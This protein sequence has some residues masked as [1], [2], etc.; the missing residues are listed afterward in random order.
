MARLEEGTALPGAGRL[1]ERTR[2]I[3]RSTGAE[4]DGVG[5]RRGE[6]LGPE[7]VGG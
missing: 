2:L 5:G 7:V 6:L 1:R 3:S 4:I